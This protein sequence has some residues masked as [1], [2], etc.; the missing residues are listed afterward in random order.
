MRRAVS[1]IA[2]LVI[3]TSALAQHSSQNPAKQL[4][5]APRINQPTRDTL[6]VSTSSQE[7]RVL[8]E[9]GIVSWENLQLDAAL[10]RWRTAANVDPDFA[11]AHLMLAYCTPDPKEEKAERQTAE[12]LAAKVTPDERLLIVWLDGIRENN[13][14]AGIAAMN[15]L[16]ERYPKDK[17]LLMWS[18]SWLFHQQEYERAQKKLEQA[19]ALDPGFASAWN[20]LGYIYAFQADYGR[21]LAAMQHYVEL[22]PNEPN[23][24]DSYA[25]ILRLAGRYEEAV[26]HYRLALR[27]DSN[28]HS[29]QVGIADT[30]SLMGQQRKARQEYFKARVLATDRLTELQ[31]LM[32]SAFSYVRDRDALGADGAFEEVVQQAHRAGLPVLEA[33]AWRM[34]ARLH[35]VRQPDDLVKSEVPDT[36]RHL[37]L[38]R[39]KRIQMPESEYLDRAAQVI[40]TAKTISESDRQDEV[41]RILCERAE[42]DARQGLFADAE[43][44]LE[45]LEKMANQVTSVTVQHAF[46]EAQGAVFVYEGKYQQAISALQRDNDNVFSQFRLAYAAQ[47]VGDVNL[48]KEHFAE[49]AQY[50]QPTPEQA[51]LTT[52]RVDDL[53]EPVAAANSEDRK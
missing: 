34:R 41:A 51:V 15:D 31:D 43:Q 20:D 1:A 44:A 11:L 37:P 24:Q 36:S 19:V 17:Q 10:K 49:I 50:R 21:A 4:K 47:K 14:V 42:A 23:P 22:L 18:G 6:P 52:M 5:R 28:F 53:A 30:Y 12:S 7:A 29:S 46:D 38:L 33:E 26:E 3:A 13:Y 2:I 45:S 25:E 8:Y 32:Q 48:A 9:S 27:I 39:R 40:Q 16:L 35:F